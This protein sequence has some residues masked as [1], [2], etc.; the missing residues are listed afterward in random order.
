MKIHLHRL[1]SEAGAGHFGLHAQRDSFIG[2]NPNDEDVLI[3][4]GR[5]LIEKNERRFFEMN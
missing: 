5:F 1:D 2:L 3:E 4:S